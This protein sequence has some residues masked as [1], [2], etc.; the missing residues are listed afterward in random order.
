MMARV[1]A[2]APLYTGSTLLRRP[3]LLLRVSPAAP[4]TAASEQPRGKPL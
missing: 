4:R 1:Q 2:P 3:C